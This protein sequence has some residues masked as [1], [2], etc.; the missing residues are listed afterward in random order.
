MV[1]G[2]EG[3][4]RVVQPRKTWH[5]LH[6]S[7]LSLTHRGVG[8]LLPREPYDVIHTAD[9]V[10]TPWDKVSLGFVCVRFKL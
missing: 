5:S 10:A 4:A 9:H 8:L 6:H 1:W 7:Y 3:K 2:R